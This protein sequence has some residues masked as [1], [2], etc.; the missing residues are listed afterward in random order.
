MGMP[1][2][3]TYDQ[4]GW[5]AR[6]NVPDPTGVNTAFDAGDAAEDIDWTQDTDVL[7]RARVIV[8][9]TNAAATSHA[10]MA[11][12]FTLQYNNGDVE[13]LNVGAVGGGTEDVD[14]ANASG[15]A[16]GDDTTSLLTTDTNNFV[17]GD[18]VENDTVSDN[19]TCRDYPRFV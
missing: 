12:E 11:T 18:G 4:D 16:D 9:Q 1:V 17:T 7:F 10:D 13:W 5:R 15:F 3:P 6:T 8:K 14:F 2:A 19:R